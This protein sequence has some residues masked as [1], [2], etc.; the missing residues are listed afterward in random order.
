MKEFWH[1]FYFI[2]LLGI[3]AFA[4]SGSLKAIKEGLDLLGISVLAILTALGGGII[5]DVIVNTIP[6]AF[7]SKENMIF[8]VLGLL[9]GIFVYKFS[10]LSI[11]NSM[12]MLISDAIGLSAF[13]ATGA[14]IAY[15][16]GVNVFGIVILATITGVGGGIIGDILLGKIPSVLKDDFYASCSI[17]GSFL[18]YM[19]EI[20]FKNITLSTIVC[21]LS[22]FLIRIFAI[23]FKW[24]LP[25]FK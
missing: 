23:V 5:R 18:F 9:I 6:I 2:N 10:K 3:V 25:K 8:A 14:M 1:L 4:I 15:N 24:S 16:A 13:S 7:K 20:I 12:F 19:V 17:I 11:E 22:V 21:V